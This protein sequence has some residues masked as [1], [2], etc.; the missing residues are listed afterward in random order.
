V[1]FETPKCP[2]S[3]GFGNDADDDNDDDDEDD[4]ESVDEDVRAFG[5][6]KL[7]AITSPFLTP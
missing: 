5:K 7:G 2:P 4:Y 6:R 1:F 3:S